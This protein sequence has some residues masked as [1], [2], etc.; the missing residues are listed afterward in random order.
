MP[1][2]DPGSFFP[3]KSMSLGIVKAI[4][5]RAALVALGTC[6]LLFAPNR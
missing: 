6:F 1:D 5:R 3:D 4:N 2:L